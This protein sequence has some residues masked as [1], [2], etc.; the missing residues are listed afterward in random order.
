MKSE[1]KGQKKK[2]R[3]IWVLDDTKYLKFWEIEKL[4]NVC[5][6][7]K[8]Q[9]LRQGKI[10]PVRNWFIVELGLFTGLRVEEMQN[11]R[12]EDLYLAE[13]QSSL[14]VRCGK[15]DKPRVVRFNE[16]FKN[17]CKWFLKWKQRQGQPICNEN[18]IFTNRT[19]KQLCKKTLQNAFKKCVKISGLGGCY[20]IHCLRHTYGSYLYISS[21][22][23]LRLVQEHLGH[24]SIR[25]TEVYASL[26]N[27]DVKKAVE[28][29]YKI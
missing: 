21:N 28:N 22:H 24:S 25:T 10:I 3:F 13:G 1:I 8:N 5:R 29:L 16:E 15:G 19:G 14:K 17:R 6:R 11:L 4:R 27:P 18:F 23:N 9:A 26:M 7:A 12:C 2:K 20:S